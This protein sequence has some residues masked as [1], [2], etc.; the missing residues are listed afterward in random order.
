LEFPETSQS[1]IARIKDLAD[2][3]AWTEFLGI[4]RPVVYR[5]ARR[6][7]M[8]DADAQDVTQRV[9]LA[10]AQAINNWQ[11]GPGRPPF[12]AWLVT[13]TRN[14]ATKALARRRPDMG[15][16]S[17]S[18]VELLN[19]EPA[20]EGATA[21]FKLDSRRATIRWAAEQIRPQ[22]SEVTWRLFWETVIEG[23]AVSEVAAETGRSAGAIYMARFH[24]SQRLKEK[25]L[26]VSAQWE[27]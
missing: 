22:F 9:F 13:I 12:R 18:V 26:E 16:G 23:R 4:Y 6:R 3:A 10:I 17:T 11:P 7:G 20:D 19:A 15:A 21:E 27:I 24:V 2:E 8:Q 25:V 1:L 14:A 5:M